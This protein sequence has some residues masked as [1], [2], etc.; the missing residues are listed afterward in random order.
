[1]LRTAARRALTLSWVAVIVVLAAPAAAL[2]GTQTSSSGIVT[3][4]FSYT[5]TPP[6]NISFPTKTLTIARSGQ[7]VYDQPVTSK[8]CGSTA[9]AQVYCAPTYPGVTRTSVHVVDLDVYLN[10]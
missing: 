2:A 10:E 1:M 7:V 8:Y 6:P 3:A 5:F 4:T 9:A